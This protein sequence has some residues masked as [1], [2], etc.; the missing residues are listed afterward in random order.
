MMKENIFTLKEVS[1]ILEIPQDRI[2]SLIDSKK[3]EHFKVGKKIRVSETHLSSYLKSVSHKKKSLIKHSFFNKISVI[4]S[5]RLNNIFDLYKSF[6]PNYTNNISAKTDIT[7]LHNLAL[8]REVD[9]IIG[10]KYN[11]NQLKKLYPEKIIVINNT[12][13]IS[14]RALCK[15]AKKETTELSNYIHLGEL[16]DYINNNSIHVQNKLNSVKDN[17][18]STL[19]EFIMVANI[20]FVKLTK[21]LEEILELKKHN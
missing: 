2:L 4:I 3:L 14:K 20:P 21:E 6:R 19:F 18:N 8:L 5:Q 9:S 7:S 13:F 15:V 16:S 10:V 11:S 12:D 1:A 17:I